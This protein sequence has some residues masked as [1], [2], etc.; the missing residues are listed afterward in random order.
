MTPKVI[1]NYGGP[2]VDS[3]AI[4]NPETD[5]SADNGNRALEDLAQLTRT[6]PKA[7][8]RFTAT[9]TAAPTTVEPTFWDTIW[10]SGVSQKPTINKTAT[11]EYTISW[12]TSYVD[13]LGVTETVSFTYFDVEAWTTDKTEDIRYWNGKN[14]AGANTASVALK[15]AN[16][17]KDQTTGGQNIECQIV[18]S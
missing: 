15:E 3:T 18:C 11:G 2:F 13:A 5:L 7:M 1:G 10:G 12:A 14:L 17:I 16:T 4:E 9:T 8:V 6:K